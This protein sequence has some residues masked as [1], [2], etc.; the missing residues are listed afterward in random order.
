M[1][2]AYRVV[3]FGQMRLDRYETV[4]D[5]MA[6]A[7]DFLV[8]R[9]AEH[10]LILGICTN[11]RFVPPP[12]PHDPP[13]F[14]TVTDGDAVVLASLRA[15]P[16]N[17]VLSETDALPAVDLVADALVEVA[18]PGVLGP[19][20]VAARFAVRWSAG[21]GRRMVIDM[22]ERIFRLSR[23]IPPRQPATGRWRIAGP[24]DR[25]LLAAWLTAFAAEATPT[26]PMHAADLE[27]MVDRWIARL[28]RT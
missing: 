14:A 9:E 11:L 20:E 23:V 5:F 26:Q 28:G 24:A 15:P 19:R 10:N 27:V 12:D 1:G 8:A 3:P 17:Q 13:S 22:R 25:P 18:L 16:Y 4:D 2:E 21:T 7:G 6:H